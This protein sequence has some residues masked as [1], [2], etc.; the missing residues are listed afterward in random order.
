MSYCFYLAFLLI[1]QDSADRHRL[2]MNICLIFINKDCLPCSKTFSHI[3]CLHVHTGTNT[4]AY[5]Q[6]HMDM[7]VCVEGTG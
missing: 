7:C 6:T 3:Y 5:M 1:H 4:C 2:L